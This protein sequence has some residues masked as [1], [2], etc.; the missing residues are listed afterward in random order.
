MGDVNTNGKEG[1]VI[2]SQESIQTNLKSFKVD[3]FL[4]SSSPSPS[5]SSLSPFSSSSASI[6]IPKLTILSL[7]SNSSYFHLLRKDLIDNRIKYAKKH[8]Y[9]YLL[10]P[11]CILD[12]SRH[13]KYSKIISLLKAFEITPKGSW[14]WW[15]DSDAL[16]MDHSFP[17][18]SIILDL[19]IK[20]NQ[21]RFNGIDD[22]QL[23]SKSKG[24]GNGN[25]NGKKEF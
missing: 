8:E 3:D 5:S 7:F 4:G 14:I 11:G 15:L 6:S 24:I 12:S 22:E 21:S 17:A 9:G 2:C 23:K 18:Y 19:G 13:D 16:I 10:F 20:M 1:K 25:G